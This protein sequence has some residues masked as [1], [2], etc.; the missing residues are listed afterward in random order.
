MCAE[1]WICFNTVHA[2]VKVLQA[3]S[4]VSHLTL[5]ESV[6]LLLWAAPCGGAHIKTSPF[7]VPILAVV[8]PSPDVSGC[9][10]VSQL[11]LHSSSLAP[12][13]HPEDVQEG[14]SWA[15]GLV[16]VGVLRV[17]FPALALGVES[18]GVCLFHGFCGVSLFLFHMAKVR[19]QAG[20]LRSRVRNYI[21]RVSVFI[22]IRV[23][24]KLEVMGKTLSFPKKTK[25]SPGSFLEVC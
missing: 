21:C 8:A 12:S 15:V 6:F 1:F 11:M 7:L 24:P 10:A 3:Y 25:G 2:T 18:T 9:R 5:W 20:H 23:F 4:A 16:L 17:G 22:A 14:G 19:V 13:L